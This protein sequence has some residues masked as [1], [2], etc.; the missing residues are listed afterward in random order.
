LGPST[1]PATLLPLLELEELELELEDL[2]LELELDD[3]E[4]LELELLE[5]ELLELELLELELPELE[6]LELELELLEVEPGLEPAP[7]LP[8]RLRAS[9]LAASPPSARVGESSLG[10]GP[11][12]SPLAACPSPAPL[13]SSCG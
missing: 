10:D 13:P 8:W 7:A 3:L 11:P 6:L 5:L 1:P 12:T 2:E 4:L 9:Q